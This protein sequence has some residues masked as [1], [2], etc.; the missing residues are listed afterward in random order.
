MASDR[1]RYCLREVLPFIAMVMVECTNVGLS[2]IFKAASNKGLD[3]HVFMVYTY[4][5]ST[6]VAIPL[7]FIFHR[8]TE[9]PPI[10]ITFLLQMFLIGCMG[11][12]AQMVG[13]KGIEYASPTLG[14][15][16]S[17]L[18]P[19]CTFVL[20]ILFRMEKLTIRRLS[21]QAKII[22]TIVS[23]CGALIVV[24]YKG[25]TII[26][27]VAPSTS[28]NSLFDPST[29]VQSQWVIGGGLLAL[30]YVIVSIWYIFQAKVVREYPAELL[31]VFFYNLSC[32]IISTPVCFIAQPNLSAWK[33]KLDIG[34][35][36]ILYSGIVG[37]FG[38]IVH[39][40]GL[41]VKGPVYVALFRPLSIAIAAVMGVIVLGDA[42]YLGS[43][44]G[45]IT[46]SFGFYVV[47]WAKTQE[48]VCEELEGCNQLDS[49]ASTE[50]VPLLKGYNTKEGKKEAKP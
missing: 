9:L 34:L 25:P 17:N 46:I 42:L 13:Y 19:A 29:I 3:Y 23:I 31:V 43:I 24:L 35:A 38:T 49:S 6:L 50:H 30:E 5:I 40:W 44:I 15:A 20:A 12:T 10:R 41:H 22:G 1:G 36:A 16:M 21:S 33:I 32:T 4:V 2:T 7:T 14:S 18:T 45:A 8:K 26:R 37:S 48:D 11:F 47:M 28:L 27:S 39:T